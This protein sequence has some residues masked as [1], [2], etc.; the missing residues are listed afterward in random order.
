MQTRVHRTLKS[1]GRESQENATHTS[2]KTK[3]IIETESNT[4]FATQEIRKL[5]TP[6]K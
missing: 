1:I 2:T 6:T 3:C 4:T 5:K